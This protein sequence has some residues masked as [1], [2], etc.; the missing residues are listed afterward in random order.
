MTVE[1]PF[2]PEEVAKLREW[3]ACDWVHPFTCCEHLT[4]DVTERGFVCRRCG[5]EQHWC[6]DFMTKGAPPNPL[7]AFKS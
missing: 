1:A 3:Q 6:H 5:R 2:T 4:M 7:D